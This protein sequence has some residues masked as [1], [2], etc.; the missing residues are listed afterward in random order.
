MSGLFEGMHGFNADISWWNVS[1]VKDMSYMFLNASEFNQNIGRWRVGN[2]EKIYGMF[3]GAKALNKDYVKDFITGDKKG[4][5][6]EVKNLWGGLKVSQRDQRAIKEKVRDVRGANG[7][8]S[9]AMKRCEYLR[10]VAPTSLQLLSRLASL[11]AVAVALSSL[12]PF[13]RRR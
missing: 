7:M 5:E 13:A 6:K 1:S 12:T 9:E 11:L 3:N 8:P 2:V 10:D 4:L